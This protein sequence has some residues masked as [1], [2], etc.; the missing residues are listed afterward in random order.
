MQLFQ[1]RSMPDKIRS[2]KSSPPFGELLNIFGFVYGAMYDG[3]YDY[4]VKTTVFCTAR[5]RS[6][7]QNCERKTS[8]CH[9]YINCLFNA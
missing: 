6:L 7:G 9:F 2:D 3:S 5:K 8:F 1:R 4:Q